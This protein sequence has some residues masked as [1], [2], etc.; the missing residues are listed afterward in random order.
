MIGINYRHSTL[1]TCLYGSEISDSYYSLLVREALQAYEEVVYK[2]Q[3]LILVR[4]SKKAR[5]MKCLLITYRHTY[6]SHSLRRS[7]PLD[8]LI[9]NSKFKTYLFTI[10][11]VITL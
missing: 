5:K 2:G 1:H 4:T 9:S 10:A 6:L 3:H 7:G 11:G 8:F